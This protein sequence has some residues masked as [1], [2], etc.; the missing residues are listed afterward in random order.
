VIG[1]AFERREIR[2]IDDHVLTL[3]PIYAILDAGCFADSESLISAA[4]KMAAAGI[5]LIQ[6]RDKS[7]D[8]RRM[9]NTACE[10][11]R[12]VGI[13]AKLIMNDRI[14]LAVAAGFD[15]VHLGQDDLSAEG[16]RKVVGRSLWLGVS[17]HNDQQVVE[18]DKTPAD[19][20]AIGPVLATSS[21]KE[22]DPVVG[23]DGVRR[24][25]ALTGKSLVAIGGITLETCRSVIEAGANSVALISA[26]LPDPRKSGE[27]FLRILR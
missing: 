11:K 9:L 7:G 15:G 2:F 24:A 27:E 14:D 3:P 25:R 20:I 4:D 8:A 18:A 12:R 1:L 17:T 22:P 10:L 23:L 21:K 13:K 19:Y 26:L 16:A 6:Y 5:T